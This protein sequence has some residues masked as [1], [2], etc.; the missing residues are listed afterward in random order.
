MLMLQRIAAALLLVLPPSIYAQGAQTAS[1]QV[2]VLTTAIRMNSQTITGFGGEPQL[3]ANRLVIGP[4]G[5][6]SAGLGLQY[7]RHV[8]GPDHITI[9]GGFVEPRYT[10]ATSGTIFPYLGARAAFLRQSNN[11]STSSSGAAFGGGGGVVMAL[12]DRVNLDFGGALIRQSFSDTKHNRTGQTLQ[13][14]PF[15][16]YAIKAGV[17]LGLGR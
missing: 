11:F 12:S 10:F 15:F 4:N 6:L 14:T 1:V 17:N 8:S 16:G 13:F 2:S 9:A 5:V 3:R 7:T